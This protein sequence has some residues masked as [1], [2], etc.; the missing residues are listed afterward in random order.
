MRVCVY[1]CIYIYKSYIRFVDHKLRTTLTSKLLNQL[2]LRVPF[3][4]VTG[5]AHPFRTRRL[6]DLVA[7]PPWP[8]AGK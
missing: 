1:K 6:Q 7:V 3:P 2:D 4:G 5:G 8:S